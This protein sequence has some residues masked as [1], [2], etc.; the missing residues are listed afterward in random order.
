MAN[1]ALVENP[2]KIPITAR[3]DAEVIDFFKAQGEGYQTRMNAVL[4]SYVRAQK[5][6]SGQ[7]G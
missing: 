2:K 6:K 5:A 7:G 4:L 3:F 1:A